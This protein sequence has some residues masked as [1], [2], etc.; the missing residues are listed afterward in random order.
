MPEHHWADISPS[1]IL[2]D[3]T[4]HLTGG[5]Q[6]AF[7][8]NPLPGWRLDPRIHLSHCPIFGVLFLHH[9][10]CYDDNGQLIISPLRIDAHK[11]GKK[12]VPSGFFFQP[13]AENISAV[14]FSASGTISK[15]NRI[16]RQAGFHDPSVTMI[17]IG[18]C[19]NHDPNA[20]IPKLFRY[21]V[22]ER[23]EETWAE[24]LSMFHNPRAINPVPRELFPSIA[25]HE[26]IDGQI[27][28]QLPDF[29]PYAS[30][31]LNIRAT[32]SG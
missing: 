23:S 21:V 9:D 26:F 6:T 4:N 28:S 27:V 30:I 16:G 29:Y 20:C 15:F 11:V 7:T 14:L 17:R 8:T 31:T 25:H 24:G 2:R 3:G 13:G 32:S 1:T 5:R 18:T 19:H 22:D 12:E 10:F